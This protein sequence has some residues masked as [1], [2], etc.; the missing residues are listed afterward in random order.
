MKLWSTQLKAALAAAA[1]AAS[2]AQAQAQ[3][4]TVGVILSTTGPG[5]V[6]GIQERN[7]LALWPTEIG[8]RKLKIIV[9]DDR[10][11]PAAA[12]SIARR[13][14][15][16]DKV[17]LLVGSSLVPG[18][19]AVAAIAQE[20][21]VVQLALA[22]MP[23]SPD[24]AVWSFN[25]TPLTSRMSSALFDHM[26]KNKVKT[27]G[28]IGFSDT[29]GDQWLDELKNYASRTGVKIVAEERFGRGD[30]SVVGQALRLMSANPDVILAGATSSAAGLVQKTL[31]DLKFKGI[32]YHTHG[33]ATKDFLRIAGKT[34]DGAIAPTGPSAVAEELPASHPSKA[35]AMTFVNAYEGRY[36]VGTRTP[37]SALLYD[38]SLVLKKAIPDALAKAQPGTKEFRVALKQAI[39]RVK[40]LVGAQAVLNYS[41]T[42]H[43]GTDDRARILV[44]VENGDW[45]YLNDQSGR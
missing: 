12:T 31:V 23:L 19:V 41:P 43:N 29:W 38:G 45:R 42:D 1:I 16:D 20:T 37:F 14:A 27:A 8:G 18:C 44:T 22:P 36:G 25:V 2:A 33:A 40:D 28:Y 26:T 39:E 11:D 9:Q 17:D 32:I 4:I 5:S 6:V 21:E 34:G 3:D 13:M 15:V 10:S 7:A 24:K 30:T 35:I